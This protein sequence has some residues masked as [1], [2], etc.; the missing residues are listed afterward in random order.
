MARANDECLI[1]APVRSFLDA[2]ASS[3]PAP[4]GGSVA[5][6]SG[7]LGAGLISMVCNLTLGK[8]KYAAVQDD[9][10]GIIKKS[11]GLR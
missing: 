4:G 8:P 3:A 6:L 1:E 10:A 7:A 11:E 9:I 2:L 5:A